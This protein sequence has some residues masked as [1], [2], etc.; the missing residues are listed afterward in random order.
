MN[1]L[2]TVAIVIGISGVV[3]NVLNFVHTPQVGGSVA[4]IFALCYTLASLELFKK[5]KE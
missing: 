5:E 2:R 1:T 3:F 4:A